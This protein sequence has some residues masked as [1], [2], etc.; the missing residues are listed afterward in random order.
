MPT[1]ISATNTRV[2]RSGRSTLGIGCFAAIL[3]LGASITPPSASAKPDFCAGAKK[4]NA[5]WSWLIDLAANADFQSATKNEITTF[6]KTFVDDFPVLAKQFTSPDAKKG[7]KLFGASQRAS[8]VDLKKS[9]QKAKSNAAAQAALLKFFESGPEL[10]DDEE[11]A[12]EEASDAMNA[13]STK[14]CGLPVFPDPT[15]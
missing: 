5:S 6:A 1:S 4:V 3:T 2:E 12:Q 8:L 15:A 13:E 11:T 10:S 14:R 7:A 9:S